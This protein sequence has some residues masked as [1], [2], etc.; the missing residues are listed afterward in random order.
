MYV[1]KENGIEINWKTIIR[2]ISFNE[3]QQSRPKII[4]DTTQSKD[5]E[6]FQSTCLRPI[7]KLQ[8]DLIIRLFVN[9]L[10]NKKIYISLELDDQ[11]ILNLIS[12]F[13]KK[14]ISI[15]STLIGMIIGQF[16]T[17]EL[18]TYLNHKSEFNKRINTML[19]ERIRSQ[20]KQCILPS[21]Q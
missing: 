16:K 8:N 19:I 21:F 3:M 6:L 2:L 1:S 13:I 18:Q 17:D 9:E 14:D 7:L 11:S 10:K 20:W 15:R 12:N 5:L 4:V